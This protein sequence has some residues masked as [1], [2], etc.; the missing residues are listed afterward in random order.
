M[1]GTG[2]NTKFTMCARWFIDNSQEFIQPKSV[3]WTESYASST[4]V[5]AIVI[6]HKKVT[7]VSGH[8]EMGEGESLQSSPTP[9]FPLE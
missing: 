2:R 1:D 6:D 9:C 8:S 7:L 3:D 4:P 5:A